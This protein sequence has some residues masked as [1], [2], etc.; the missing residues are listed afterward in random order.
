MSEPQRHH[1]SSSLVFGDR[2]DLVLSELLSNSN[3]EDKERNNRTGQKVTVEQGVRCLILTRW[4]RNKRN[5]LSSA[6]FEDILHPSAIIDIVGEHFNITASDIM[7]TKKSRNLSYPRQICMFLCREL[8]D[9]SLKDIGKKLGNRD[10]T[11]VL[12]GITKIQT[13]LQTDS[14]LNNT[15]DV[16]KKKINPQ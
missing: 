15:I 6:N 1:S 3:E 8:T 14:S 2:D 13:D 7:S 4:E 11:T 16:L 10:H 9:V 12:H 5:Y